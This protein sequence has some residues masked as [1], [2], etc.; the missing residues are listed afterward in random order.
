MNRLIIGRELY[1]DNWEEHCVECG[2]P[3]CYSACS[4]FESARDGSCRRFERNEPWR[5]ADRAKGRLIEF[6][7]WGKM[8]LLFRGKMRPRRFW[9]R[10]MGLR[11]VPTFWRLDA[12]ADSE[13]SCVC[14]IK[15]A[16]NE[17][18][19]QRSVELR[20]GRNQVEFSVPPV[21]KYARF[22]FYPLGEKNVS[23]RFRR[24][25]LFCGSTKSPNPVPSVP[26]GL[27]AKVPASFL[28]CVAWDLDNTVWDGIL[29][30]DGPDGVSLRPEAV[31]ALKELDR[32]GI[33]NTVASKNDAGP[34]IAHLKRLGIEEYFVFPEINWGPKSESLKRAAANIG[35]GMD[36]FAFVD[37]SSNERGEVAEN[38]P[39]V[40]V[41]D[42]NGIA[43]LLDSSAANPEV[44]EE[45]A[46]RRLSY[47]AEMMRKGFE[48]DYAGDYLAFLKACQLQ[49]TCGRLSS[50]A[51]VHR[52]RE[53]V[54][55]TNQLTLAARRYAKDEFD[56][57]VNDPSVSAYAIHCRDKY[58]DYGG[59]GFIALERHGEDVSVREFVMS[60]RVA[61][62]LCEQSVLSFVSREEPMLAG[63]RS[64]VADVVPTGRNDALVAA[65][66]AMPFFRCKMENGCRRYISAIADSK[67]DGQVF[68]HEVIFG[69][70]QL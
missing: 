65:F 37:D 47:R 34:A 7:P 29:V 66:D 52:C 25:E 16:Q 4:R 2:A 8:E 63:A 28:K 68:S 10:W 42:Q 23:L 22:A 9:G 43:E 36:T 32:R 56:A 62:K 11:A 59:V 14:L 57:L 24:M 1:L 33:L 46:K 44:T 40:R 17:I 3:E 18:L 54:Q 61:K 27:D 51:L 69:E 15:N 6:R 13:V 50:G 53:L 12:E 35:I 60:C 70:I 20:C 5:F 58:G 67:H 38:L 19:F 45:S 41:F 48:A 64:L 31:F 21:E 39:M 49:L 30:E 26:K 55:R